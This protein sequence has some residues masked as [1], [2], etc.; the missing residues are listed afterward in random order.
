MKHNFS[1]LSLCAV[2]EAVC[3]DG[4]RGV[5]RP[6]QTLVEHSEDGVCHTAQCT[7]GLDTSTGY[8]RIRTT[9]TNCSAL[10]QL[11]SRP[12]VKC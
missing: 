7:R 3:V 12:C 1:P 6:G 5:M 11:V 9:S 2:R 4:E 10:C 8:H